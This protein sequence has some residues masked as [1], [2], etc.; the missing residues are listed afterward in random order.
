MNKK[1]NYLA[2][3]FIIKM[4]EENVLH[5]NETDIKSSPEI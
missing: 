4:T 1:Y 3:Y 2:N 5:G